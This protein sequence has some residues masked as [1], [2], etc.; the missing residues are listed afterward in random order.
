RRSAAYSQVMDI[1]GGKM[2]AGDFTPQGRIAQSL[3]DFTLILESAAAAGQALPLA[4]IY[5]RLMRGCIEHG[6]GE[7]DNAA[8]IAA[9]RRRVTRP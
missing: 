6:E 7:L 4:E 3:K 2:I 1:K 9:I 8:V 5:R